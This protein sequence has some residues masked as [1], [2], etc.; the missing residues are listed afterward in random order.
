[1]L[2]DGQVQT[3]VILSV[4]WPSWSNFNTRYRDYC[5]KPIYLTNNID[6]FECNKREMRLFRLVNVTMSQSQK[7]R[8]WGAPSGIWTHVKGKFRYVLFLVTWKHTKALDLCCNTNELTT[9]NGVHLEKLRFSG[10]SNF[11]GTRKFIT[12][13][14]LALHWSL[15]WARWIKPLP[16]HPISVTFI[17]KKK[18][19]ISKL[20][21]TYIK[22]GAKI[23][24]SA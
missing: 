1:M 13:F 14:T 23:V 21:S 22:V 4:V 10:I 5:F 20:I 15:Y 7:P 11:Y 16:S 24:E 3:P 17:L 9:W 6:I 2:D 8:A 19:L 12:V 18:Y